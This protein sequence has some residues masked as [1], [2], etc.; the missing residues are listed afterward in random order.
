MDIALQASLQNIKIY[1][2][3]GGALRVSGSGGNF[4]L[5]N[6]DFRDTANTNRRNVLLEGF[7]NISLINGY[8]SSFG[9]VELYA[10][11]GARLSVSN[12]EIVPRNSYGEG[13]DLRNKANIFKGVLFNSTAYLPDSTFKTTFHSIVTQFHQWAIPRLRIGSSTS[14]PLKSSGS[15]TIPL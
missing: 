15:Q 12:I 7:R 2:C 6:Y 9:S 13:L 4:S 1:D 5:I 10:Y 8:L 14:P 3:E 11:Q